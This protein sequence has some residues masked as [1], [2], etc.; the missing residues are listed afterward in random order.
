MAKR[1]EADHKKFGLY[2]VREGKHLQFV[3]EIAGFN[4]AD[5]LLRAVRDG[6]AEAGVE[7]T[8]IAARN[9]A[10]NLVEETTP[11]RTRLAV[12]RVSGGA[13]PRKKGAK[14]PGR[15]KKDAAAK[16]AEAAAPASTPEPQATPAPPAP[17]AAPAAP[18]ADP[19]PFSE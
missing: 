10:V 7:Y 8:T 17:P 5:A 6:K 14:K 2:L 15:P 3:G 11:V 19:N 9:L 12:K 4:G 13:P 18:A 16:K 1:S